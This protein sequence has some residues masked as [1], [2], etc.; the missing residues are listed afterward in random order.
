MNEIC[1]EISEKIETEQKTVKK[2]SKNAERH[3]SKAAAMDSCQLSREIDM[4]WTVV[5]S[6]VKEIRQAK[7]YLPFLI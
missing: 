2:P 5:L 3:L 1:P 4:A 7:M 6:M